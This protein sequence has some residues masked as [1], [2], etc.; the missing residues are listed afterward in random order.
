MTV[1]LR[2]Y[3]VKHKKSKRREDVWEEVGYRESSAFK[4]DF[5]GYWIGCPFTPTYLVDRDEFQATLAVKYLR[6]GVPDVLEVKSFYMQA[7]RGPQLD[8]RRME[9][10]IRV[11]Q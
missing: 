11:K 3:A 5:F 1:Q 6:K 4:N 2:K 7:V 10:Q 8:K 9:A